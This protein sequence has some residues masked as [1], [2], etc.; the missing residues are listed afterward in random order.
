MPSTT[1]LRPDGRRALV[2]GR[3]LQLVFAAVF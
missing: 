2:G 3:C 1:L